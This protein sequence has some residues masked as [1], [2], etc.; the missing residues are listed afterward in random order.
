MKL[1]KQILIIIVFLAGIMPLYAGY[2]AFAHP[3]NILDMLHIAEG[4][5][6]PIPPDASMEL[7]AAMFGLFFISFGLVYLFA[8]YL[9]F[10]RRQAGRSLAILLGCIS[11]VSGLVLYS[12]YNDLHAIKAGKTFAVV[13]A[14]KGAFIV[15]LAWI[16]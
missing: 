7:I 8:G 6:I 10:K 3:Y 11:I 1:T 9:L 4:D 15:L 13:D 12:K 14:A 2:Q 16:A 5:Y